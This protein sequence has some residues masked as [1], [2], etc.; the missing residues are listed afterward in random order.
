M[1]SFCM[2]VFVE[3]DNVDFGMGEASTVFD[4]T[5]DVVFNGG[6]GV[7]FDGVVGGVF[8]GVMGVNIRPK[9]CDSFVGVAFGS[10]SSN[11]LT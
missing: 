8:D 10:T 4:G 3:K 11:I 2:K 5:I 6:V 7:V 9:V 1:F